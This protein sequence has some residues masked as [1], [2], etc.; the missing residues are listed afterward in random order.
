METQLPQSGP[1]TH[2]QVAEE[3]GRGYTDP[4]HT[5][6]DGVARKRLS[7]GVTL[8]TAAFRGAMPRW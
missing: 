3:V 8:C 7:N 6:S 5:M 2:E 1:L 4:D